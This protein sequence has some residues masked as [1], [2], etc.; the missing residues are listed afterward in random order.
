VQ[1]FST[2]AGPEFVV[3]APDRLPSLPAAVEVAAYWIVNEAITN[4]VRHASARCC[5]VRLQ[6]AGDLQLTV[7]DDG[8]GLPDGW[9]AGVGTS[10]MAE[11]ASELGGELLLR[12]RADRPGTEVYARIPVPATKVVS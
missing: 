2:G 7:S 11:R 12:A 4:V 1:S 10:S 8:G 5:E 9:R 3:T 6:L